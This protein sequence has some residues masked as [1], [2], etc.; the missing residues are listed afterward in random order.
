MFFIMNL[1]LHT[2]E[3][4]RNI[5]LLSYEDLVRI[6]LN[7]AAIIV[8]LKLVSRMFQMLYLK[9]FLHSNAD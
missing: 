6:I 2:H 8:H 5:L 4:Y 9:T 3:I 7:D 1:N